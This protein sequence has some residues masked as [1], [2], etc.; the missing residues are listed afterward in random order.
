MRKILIL[1]FIITITTV[2]AEEKIV[3]KYKYYNID[4]KYGPYAEKETDEYPLLD[5]EDIKVIKGE[6][7]EWPEEKENRIIM[8][9]T[10]YEYRKIKDIDTIVISNRSDN[11]LI[12]SKLNIIYEGRNINFTAIPASSYDSAYFIN[13]HSLVTY[14]LDEEINQSNLKIEIKSNADNDIVFINTGKGD[15]GYSSI[16]KRLTSDFTWY[17]YDT[18]L[19]NNPDIWETR[20][21]KESQMTSKIMKLIRELTVY[22]Y[23]DTL[24]RSYKETKSYAEGYFISA[25]KDFPYRDNNQYI[26]ETYTI[27]NIEVPNTYIREDKRIN[28]NFFLHFYNH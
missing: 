14:M 16:L 21:Y 23:S 13:D 7:L 25:P 24:Y 18:A 2:K 1:L 28:D 8:K 19:V 26:E 20:Q 6:T 11:P 17:G 10:I 27:T 3:R 22:E 9:Q 15:D 5:K 4:K 12:I